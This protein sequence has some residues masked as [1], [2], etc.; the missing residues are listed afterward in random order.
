[1]CYDIEKTNIIA[2]IGINHNGDINIA[3]KLIDISAVAGCDYVKFQKRNPDVCV[4][5]HQKDKIKQTPWGEMRYI[6]YKHKLEFNEYQYDDLF[7][8]ADSKNIK[9]TASVWDKDSVD[10]I[11][12]YT[13]IMKIPSALMTNDELILYARNNSKYLMVS[14]G[15]S[16]E[17]EIS[18]AVNICNPDLIFHTNSTYPSP[19]KEL[20]L[21]YIQWLKEKYPDREIGY[22]GHEY[23]LVTTFA[24][25]ALGA[26]W[27][28]RH[29]TLDRTMW[30]SD[31]ISSIEPIGLMKLV[32]GIKNI[33]LSMGEKGERFVFD[34][35]LTKREMMRD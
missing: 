32:N 15:M 6:D 14:T 29:I 1:M 35:E 21:K 19:V 33:N 20:N 12:R 18:H 24:A 13:D 17:E 9:M 5:D 27:I 26:T 11:K 25:V 4:P 31:Q 23:G 30:G 3:K 8:Y 28:E 7:S 34:S 2:E 16:D 22:S 10:F